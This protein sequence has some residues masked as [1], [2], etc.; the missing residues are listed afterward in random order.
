MKTIR[1]LEDGITSMS[2]T[3]AKFDDDLDIMNMLKKLYECGSVAVG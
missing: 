1:C 3:L 2:I